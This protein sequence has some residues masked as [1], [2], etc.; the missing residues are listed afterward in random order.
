MTKP[1]P[2]AT[3]RAGFVRSERMR[4]FSPNP[5]RRASERS[6]ANW[7]HIGDVIEEALDLLLAE[8]EKNVERLDDFHGVRA[9]TP[10]EVES[11]LL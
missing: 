1:A 8:C 10:K 7:T 11:V 9:E 4:E 2:V 3:E 5:K 6:L